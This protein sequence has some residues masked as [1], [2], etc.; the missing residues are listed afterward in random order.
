MANSSKRQRRLWDT[1]TFPGFR[2]RSTVRGVF[3]EGVGA[4]RSCVWPRRRSDAV[5]DFTSAPGS[6]RTVVVARSATP[7]AC[8]AGVFHL[9]MTV[10]IE[11]LRV[12]GGFNSREGGAVT[13]KIANKVLP[14][15]QAGAVQMVADYEQE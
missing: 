8:S 3:G 13:S 1:Y 9:E 6:S 5:S 14:E 11:P 4:R 12:G 2:P 7:C 15:V 10:G